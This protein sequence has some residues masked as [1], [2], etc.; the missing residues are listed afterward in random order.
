METKKVIAIVGQCPLLQ[1]DIQSFVQEYIGDISADVE[2]NVFDL[3]RVG[4]RD[5]GE[6]NKNIYVHRYANPSMDLHD[7]VN[8]DWEIVRDIIALGI[9]QCVIQEKIDTTLIVVRNH[10]I[11]AMETY[12]I[13]YNLK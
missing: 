13:T 4:G 5:V 2:V 1:Q 10:I 9:C 12:G 3:P 6:H 11:T 8:R 7:A